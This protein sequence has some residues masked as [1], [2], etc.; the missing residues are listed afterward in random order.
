MIMLHEGCNLYLVGTIFDNGGVSCYTICS[1]DQ[2]G[3]RRDVGTLHYCSILQSWLLSSQ[4]NCAF[5]AEYIERIWAALGNKPPRR[6]PEHWGA[7]ETVWQRGKR[8]M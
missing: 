5:T 7:G 6:K 4:N 1:D 3:S 2:H 8:T